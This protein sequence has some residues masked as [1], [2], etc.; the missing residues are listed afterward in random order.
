MQG[1]NLEARQIQESAENRQ[2]QRQQLE[3]KNKGKN[4][5]KKTSQFGRNLDLN[6]IGLLFKK[7]TSARHKSELTGNFR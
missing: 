1:R 2:A 6:A 7:Q 3:G 4:P 5:Q